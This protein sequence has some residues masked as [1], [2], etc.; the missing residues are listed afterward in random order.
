MT[1]RRGNLLECLLV[2][3]SIVPTVQ[4]MMFSKAISLRDIVNGIRQLAAS[5]PSSQR[6]LLEVVH[7]TKKR[8][9]IHVCSQLRRIRNLHACGSQRLP[10]CGADVTVPDKRP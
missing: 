7:N 3:C 10:S 1:D 9:G 5:Y 8:Y 4:Y 6:L 2:A